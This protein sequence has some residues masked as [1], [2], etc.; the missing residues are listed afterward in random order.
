MANTDSDD[1]STLTLIGAGESFKDELCDMLQRA[2]MFSDFDHADIDKLAT[3]ARAYSVEKDATIFKEGKK[4]SFMCVVIDG[5][6]DIFKE[7]YNHCQ[8]RQV[9]G[10]DVYS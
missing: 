4:G 2:Q 6:V 3:Y 8:A 9:H 10:R 5:R 1:D 7:S